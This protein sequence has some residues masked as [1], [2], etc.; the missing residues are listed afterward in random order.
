MV[1]RK[2]K[3]LIFQIICVIIFLYKY[4]P[5]FQAQ[6]I[7]Y[8][9]AHELLISKISISDFKSFSSVADHHLGFSLYLKIILNFFG[10]EHIYLLLGFLNLSLFLIINFFLSKQNNFPLEIIA[11]QIFILMSPIVVDYM[12]RPKQYFIDFCIAVCLIYYFSKDK[13]IK[14]N[15]ILPLLLITSFFSNI[16][17]I[18]FFVP[19]LKLILRSKDRLLIFSSLLLVVPFFYKSYNK[20]FNTSFREYWFIYYENSFQSFSKL[21]FNNLMFLRN[22][23]DLG[24]LP[25]IIV[26]TLFGLYR[27]YKEN[28]NAFWMILIP[29]IVLNF[30]N[31]VNFYPIGA[32][33]TDLILFPF[34]VYSFLYLIKFVSTKI[35]IVYLL[36]F[37]LPVFFVVENKKVREDSTHEILEQTILYD[38]DIMYVSYYSIPQ[39]ILFDE[40]FRKVEK[41]KG[42]CFYNSDNPKIIFMQT[43]KSQ[44]CK[45]QKDFTYIKKQI[46]DGKKILI[47]GHDSKTQNIINEINSMNVTKNMISINKFGN[48]EF[49]VSINFNN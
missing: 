19:L 38:F 47:I 2:N 49:L 39:T 22:F 41:V 20:F 17:I 12:Y 25:L 46:S 35:P 36:I 6:N 3:F 40:G 13:N 30:L 8:D 14:F 26:M 4:I 21:F 43:D 7:W 44:F 45:P 37:L 15:K 28:L 48:N 5:F 23:N 10:Q 9:D 29:V 42:K 31:L 24:L 11:V 33:R 32:G 34:I 16:L 18:Y 27:V 1:N